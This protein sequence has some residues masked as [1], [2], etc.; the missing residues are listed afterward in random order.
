[1]K[2]S[3]IITFKYNYPESATD[4][5]KDRIDSVMIDAV[6]KTF[7]ELYHDGHITNFYLIDGE[8]TNND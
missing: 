8:N 6:N 4:T 2:N 3:N 7:W 5:E 1:M